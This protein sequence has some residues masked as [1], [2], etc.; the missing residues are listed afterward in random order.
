[1]SVPNN[2]KVEIP[3]PQNR[4]PGATGRREAHIGPR[5]YNSYPTQALCQTSHSCLLQMKYQASNETP[6]SHLLLP[7]L[8]CP[9]LLP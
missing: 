8:A 5:S 9:A 4:T 2:F 3:G 1:M 6:F 7:M